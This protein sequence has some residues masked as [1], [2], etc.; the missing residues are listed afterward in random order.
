MYLTGVRSVYVPE[1]GRTS[2]TRTEIW[3]Q[4]FACCT[5]RGFVC[6]ILVIDNIKIPFY[7]REE[8]SIVEKRSWDIAV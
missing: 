7:A 1:T 3:K 4:G 8:L 6:N 5:D 2:D